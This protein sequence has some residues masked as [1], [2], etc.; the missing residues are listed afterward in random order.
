[1]GH[2]WTFDSPKNGGNARLPLALSQLPSHKGNVFGCLL[3]FNLF[4]AHSLFVL[5]QSWL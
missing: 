4:L 2:L 1:M 5:F 3:C